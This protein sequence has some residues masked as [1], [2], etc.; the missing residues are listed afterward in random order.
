MTTIEQE[1]A[2]EQ[3]NAEC[4]GIAWAIGVIDDLHMHS[5]DDGSFKEDHTYKYIKNTLRDQYK[6]LTGIDPAPGYPVNAVLLPV[7]EP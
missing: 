4:N 7:F 1:V 3:R 6:E 5:S 2:I